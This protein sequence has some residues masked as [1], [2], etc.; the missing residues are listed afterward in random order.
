[1]AA[2]PKKRHARVKRRL[3][4]R[5]LYEPLDETWDRIGSAYGHRS[6]WMRAVFNDHGDLERIELRAGRDGADDVAIIDRSNPQ[7]QELYAILASMRFA[8]EHEPPS[9]QEH[10]AW[11]RAIAETKC[12]L[13]RLKRP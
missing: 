3:L 6:G 2:S 10:A 12:I 1:M 13:D 8:V 5:I 11:R 9:R 7:L 4:E